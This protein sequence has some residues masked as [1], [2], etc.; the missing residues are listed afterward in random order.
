ME[1]II[2]EDLPS[3]ETPLNAENLNQIQTNMENAIN[4]VN[5]KFNY[6]TEEQIVGTWIDKKP[7]YR[8]VFTLGIL[9]GEE[10]NKIF[11]ISGDYALIIN[12]IFYMSNTGTRNSTIPINTDTLSI[13]CF[14][15][16]QADGSILITANRKYSYSWPDWTLYAILEYTKTTD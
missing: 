6:S 13:T 11:T 12:K 7:I 14:A 15:E 3:T 9:G 10:I 8:R 5:N 2:F 16:T 4:E 1:K